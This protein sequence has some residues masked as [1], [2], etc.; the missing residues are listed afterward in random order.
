MPKFPHRPPRLKGLRD[1]LSHLSDQEYTA[2][3]ARL[4]RFIEIARAIERDLAQRDSTKLSDDS[5]IAKQ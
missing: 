1:L 3:E 2:A 5:R 4:W